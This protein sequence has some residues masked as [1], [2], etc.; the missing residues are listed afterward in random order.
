MQELT[1]MPEPDVHGNQNVSEPDPDDCEGD[2]SM[3]LEPYVESGWNHLNIEMDPLH[4]K[5]PLPAS[6][7]DRCEESNPNNSGVCPIEPNFNGDFQRRVA[8]LEPELD[9]SEAD[10]NHL[11]FQ[12]TVQPDQMDFISLRS[13]ELPSHVNSTPG[14]P[15]PNDSHAEEMQTEPDSG[16]SIPRSQN[17]EPDPDDP[18]L[19]II[20]DPVTM[21][22]GRLQGAI[23]SLK[24]EVT[25]SESGRVLQT[26][27]KIIGY[28]LD[29]S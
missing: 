13:V 18:E 12:K 9:D 10:P 14:E 28:V 27:I 23:Q 26:L 29:L 1:A 8:I 16:E 11:R 22:C 24:Y 20:Q 2:E 19:Q 5:G 21:F 3:V 15:C 7:P 4:V 6:E 25:P 17:P